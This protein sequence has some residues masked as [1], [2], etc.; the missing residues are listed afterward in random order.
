MNLMLQDIF[1][2]VT[3]DHKEYIYLVYGLSLFSLH[4]GTI[5]GNIL[6]L[7]KEFKKKKVKTVFFLQCLTIYF[8]LQLTSDYAV[9]HLG[10]TDDQL[11]RIQV[12]SMVLYVAFFVGCAYA[13]A[14]NSNV[15][16]SFLKRVIFIPVVMFIGTIATLLFT[17]NHTVA[18]FNFWI[19][20]LFQRE[21]FAYS[22][23]KY[24]VSLFNLWYIGVN[25]INGFWKEE[26]VKDNLIDY[27]RTIG[28][29]ESH[30]E[31]VRLL[32]KQKEKD[33]R[34]HSNAK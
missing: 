9:K 23:S 24:V 5:L 8:S 12:I 29:A 33:N 31:F 28:R 6:S 11:I 25:R 34:E 1:N 30:A 3:L 27:K 26:E 20:V 7:F 21:H 14:V 13:M 19:A 16:Y 18:S 32:E 10:Y 2:K 22:Y 4:T 17:H 15:G